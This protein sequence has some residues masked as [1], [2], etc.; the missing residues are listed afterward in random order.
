MGNSIS[1]CGRCDYI[2]SG[3]WSSVPI[4]D[5]LANDLTEY[6]QK[7]IALRTIIDYILFLF[8]GKNSNLE[9]KFISR[10]NIGHFT[11]V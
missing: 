8:R 6:G 11:I 1:G 5:Y 3:L 9:I 10:W 4:K 7:N 2:S